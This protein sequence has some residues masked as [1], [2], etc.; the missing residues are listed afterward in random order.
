MVY[1]SRVSFNNKWFN[2][3]LKFCHLFWNEGVKYPPLAQVTVMGGQ[4]VGP[5][6]KVGILFLALTTTTVLYPQAPTTT[7]T[8]V[9]IK[10][11]TGLPPTPSQGISRIC[12]CTGCDC[13]TFWYEDCHIMVTGM[14][15][16]ISTNI[17]M[18]S[19]VTGISQQTECL[20][21]SLFT[22][23]RTFSQ[24]SESSFSVWM[25]QIGS[26]TKGW[27]RVASTTF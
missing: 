1:H 20:A 15:V 5:N 8:P 9:R 27:P 2:L 18:P 26:W 25:G 23:L 4:K 6:D 21:V 13:C 10:V 24:M 11:R 19:M 7:S 17:L 3:S 12:I 16:S 22:S 14:P